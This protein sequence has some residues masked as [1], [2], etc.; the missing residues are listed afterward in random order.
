MVVAEVLSVAPHPKADRLRVCQVDAGGAASLKVVTNAASVEEGMKVVFAVSAGWLGSAGGQV[1]RSAAGATRGTA[2][3]T[4]T[5]AAAGLVRCRP[6]VIS[7]ASVSSA[8]CACSLAQL[9]AQP[10]GCTTRNGMKIEQAVLR[11]VESFGML[12]SAHECGWVSEPGALFC[13]RGAAARA[14]RCCGAAAVAAA[15]RCC[16]AHGPA[17]E[18]PPTWRNLCC[19]RR[20]GGDARR[21]RGGRGVPRGAAQGALH[22]CKLVTGRWLLAWRSMGKAVAAAFCRCRSRHR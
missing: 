9:P 10:V 8:A 21:R 4:A 18:L 13:G 3:G 22:W 19:R 1:L 14:H 6:A 2:A 5:R 16:R 7:H 17:P 12:C 20:A 15:G 11:G